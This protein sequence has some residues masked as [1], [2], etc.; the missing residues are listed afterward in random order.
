MNVSVLLFILNLFR[1]NVSQ[2][3]L[4]GPHLVLYGLCAEE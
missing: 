2:P 1:L 4:S 3:P